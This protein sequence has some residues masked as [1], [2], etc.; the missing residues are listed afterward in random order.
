MIKLIRQ[1]KIGNYP[2]FIHVDIVDN[3]MKSDASKRR[4]K[5]KAK[6][7]SPAD[8]DS[9]DDDEKDDHDNDDAK[10]TKNKSFLSHQEVFKF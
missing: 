6:K 7:Q 8:D 9:D 4:T 1:Q 2:D 5:K 3:S 10:K